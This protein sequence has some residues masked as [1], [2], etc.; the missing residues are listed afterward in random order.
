MEGPILFRYCLSALVAQPD[1]LP[2]ESTNV[3]SL[4]NEALFIINLFSRCHALWIIMILIWSDKC[5]T[6]KTVAR[7][8][9]EWSVNIFTILFLP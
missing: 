1:T 6:N 2:L 9:T 3:S 5:P 7:T 4:V 8:L